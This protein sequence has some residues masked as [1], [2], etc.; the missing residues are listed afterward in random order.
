MKKRLLLTAMMTTLFAGTF[1]LWADD[2]RD[3]D[4]NDAFRYPAYQK[5]AKT[6]QR[7][8]ADKGRALFVRECSACHMA[9]QPE[10]LPKRSW[11]KMM[12]TLEDHFDTDASLDRNETTQIEAYLLRNAADAKRI[13]GDISEIARGI[14]ADETPQRISETRGFKKEH[15]KIPKRF[16][17]QKEVKSI[18]NCMACHTKADKGNYSE[19]TILIPNYGRWDD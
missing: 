8:M 13:Y 18:A 17:E 10:F 9:Y 6:S 7:P 2:D 15:R 16:I 4:R 12:R 1:L 11:A 5:Q 3:D 19:R 14:R